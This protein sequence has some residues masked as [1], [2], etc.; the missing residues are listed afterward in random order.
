MPCAVK[1]PAT[2]LIDST[3]TLTN[4]N[5]SAYFSYSRDQRIR[6]STP[7]ER[8][9]LR[10]NYFQRVDL[11]ASFSYSA[12]DMSTP[13][14]EAFNGLETRT[15]DRAFLGTG[16]G[17]ANRISDVL[18]LGATVH[19]TTHLRL[20]E[21]FYFWAFRIP[22]NGNFTEIDSVCTGLCT[23]LTPLSATAPATATTLTLASFNQT[24]KRNQT[25]VAWDISKKARRSHWLPLWRSGFQ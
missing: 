2:S 5:C 11:V 8:V 17:S 23:L 15:S 22:Q 19:L 14:D 24:W 9:G 20:I 4:I 12:A 13:L 21:K 18:D 3:G 7:T 6:T 1:P 25:E 10:S 16:T